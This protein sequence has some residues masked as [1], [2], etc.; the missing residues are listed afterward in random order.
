MQLGATH[1]EYESVNR[2]IWGLQ[3]DMHPA[4][5]FLFSVKRHDWRPLFALSKEI[6]AA[7]SGGVHFPTLEERNGAWA[8]FN[9]AR[10][11][12]HQ[13]SGEEREKF[14]NQS[15]THRDNILEHIKYAGYSKFTLFGS[16]LT[17][18]DMRDKSRLITEAGQMLAKHKD[19]ML[20][21]HK[22][23]CWQRI[24]ELRSEPDIFWREQAEAFSERQA[25]RSEQ[26]DRKQDQIHRLSEILV[27]KRSFLERQQSVLAENIE[28]LSRTRNPAKL[29]EI[30]G[31]IADRERLIASVSDDIRSIEA[32]IDELEA[33]VSELKRH[34]R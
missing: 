10:S 6:Q 26:L 28:R 21:E 9:E 22:D 1:M 11:L 2:M 20:R 19:G 31:W 33:R 18:D 13:R 7:F 4:P 17:P 29:L 8:K 27:G 25:R 12:L 32:R 3:K 23:E 5:S 16:Q 24:K 30:G 34:L 15:R 14:G